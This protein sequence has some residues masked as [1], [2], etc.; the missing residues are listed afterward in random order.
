MK[1]YDHNL[2]KM[3]ENEKIGARWEVYNYHL[4]ELSDALSVYWSLASINKPELDVDDFKTFWITRYWVVVII[5]N[6]KKKCKI[7]F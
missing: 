6:V 7:L 2:M 4:R 3:K 1:Y 5:K